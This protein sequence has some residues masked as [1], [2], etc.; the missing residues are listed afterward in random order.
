MAQKQNF[1]NIITEIE[2][3]DEQIA[4]AQK[5]ITQI[6]TTI[7]YGNINYTFSTIFLAGKES[8]IF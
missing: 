1:D 7:N 5:D 4:H 2:S 8:S 3:L 6:K